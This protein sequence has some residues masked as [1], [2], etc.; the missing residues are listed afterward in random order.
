MVLPV[1][2][3]QVTPVSVSEAMLQFVSRLVYRAFGSNRLRPYEQVCINAWRST[4]PDVLQQKLDNQLERFELV[5]RQARGIKSVFFS[6][7]DPRYESWGDDI[8]F[9]DRGEERKVFTGKL[10]GKIGDVTES[11]GFS[12]Y[13][14]RGR[15]SSIEFDSEPGALA[16][17]TNGLTPV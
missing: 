7:R 15:L 8:L 17:L 10:T 14:H 13:L 11:V 6:I 4:L 12:V 9:P 16:T 2:A 1:R 5:Q 3:R